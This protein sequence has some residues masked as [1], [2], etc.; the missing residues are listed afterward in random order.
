MI[1]F[2]CS[3]VSDSATPWTAAHRPPCPS[4][5]PR[6]CSN[7]CP[8]SRWCHPTISSSV[9]HFSSCH[10]Y[11]PGSGSLPVSQFFTSGGQSIGVFSFS[12]SPSNEYSRLISFRM[13]W[14]DLLAVQ[15]TLKSLVQHHRSKA[16]ILSALSFL[17]SPTFT[18]THDYWKSHSFDYMGFVAKWCFCFSIHCLYFS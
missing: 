13:D 11:F 9:V 17:Y 10:Q 15:G 18:S 7:S 3:V 6:P 14:L 16:S 2:S 12:V 1:Q 8:V 5:N 4:P